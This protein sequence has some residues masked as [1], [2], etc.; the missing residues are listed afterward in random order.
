M[1]NIMTIEQLEEARKEIA[2]LLVLNDEELKEAYKVVIVSNIDDNDL[3]VDN[4]RA[5]LLGIHNDF[6]AAAL[7]HKIETNVT[8]H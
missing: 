5:F 8:K 2:E 1:S 4:L 7:L 3:R 6:F